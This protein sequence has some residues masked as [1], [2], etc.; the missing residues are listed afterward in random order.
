M[1]AKRPHVACFTMTSG[2]LGASRR[3]LTHHICSTQFPLNN[4]MCRALQVGG[5]SDTPGIRI[6]KCFKSF[7]SRREADEYIAMGRVSINGA[8][9]TAGMRVHQGDQV[10]LDEEEVQWERLSIP[11]QNSAFAY[12]KYWKPLD[13]VCTT[14]TR[15]DN[16][17][18]D[19]IRGLPRGHDRIFPVG[20][21]DEQSTGI[22]L[23]TSDGRVPNAVLGARR[24]CVKEYVVIS[25]MRI[26][27]E[28]LDQL[29][30][31]I[32][33]KT[34]TERDRGVRKERIDMTLPCECDRGPGKEIVLKIREGRN[35]QI[36]KMLGFLGYT[37]RKIHRRSFMG[38]TLSGLE[39]P[40]DWSYL[41]EHEMALINAKL[42][43][44]S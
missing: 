32:V 35:R 7:A 41:N 18:I 40:G 2:I 11:T 4:G 33:I 3:V 28:H 5:C 8:V 36:R 10:C 29:R 30:K 27:N 24:N 21:L 22:M 25:D 15:I 17:V 9:A 39:A 44:I 42:G 20:R 12:L 34:F 43:T 26:K 23:L 6:N 13:V 38:I 1:L 31:G 16:N 14:D 37:V 19:A